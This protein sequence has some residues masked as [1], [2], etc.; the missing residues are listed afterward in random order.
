MKWLENYLKSEGFEVF[1][2]RPNKRVMAFKYSKEDKSQFAIKVTKKS[3]LY[4]M[5]FT[6]YRYDSV[7]ELEYMITPYMKDIV[8]FLKKY[9]KN[10]F[11]HLCEERNLK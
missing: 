11:R 3:G 7:G 10:R 1:G 5:D 8:D 6:D 4:S 9:N 2:V